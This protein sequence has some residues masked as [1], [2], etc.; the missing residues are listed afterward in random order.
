MG[1][2]VHVAA[3]PVRRSHI[4]T[5]LRLSLPRHT[6]CLYADWFRL[7]SGSSGERLQLLISLCKVG[8]HPSSYSSPRPTTSSPNLTGLACLNSEEALP[9]MHL[10]PPSGALLP[11][12]SNPLACLIFNEI[13]HYDHGCTHNNS[14]TISLTQY[15]ARP[16][17]RHLSSIYLRR[18]PLPI[19]HQPLR[20]TLIPWAK[21]GVHIFRRDITQPWK[22]HFLTSTP[23]AAPHLNSTPSR[24]TP[25]MH[26]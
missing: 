17:A 26:Y 3:R 11:I 24:S 14:M 25:V 19:S 23:K 10:H 22:E 4:D 18:L 20:S 7:A 5:F 15:L 6:S 12:R 13:F 21:E 16:H 1:L 8:Q 2:L 9:S